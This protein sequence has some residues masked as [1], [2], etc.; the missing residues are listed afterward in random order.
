M[1][2]AFS[3][4]EL[5]R[6]DVQALLALH[7]QAMRAASPPHACHVLALDSLRDP[8]ITFWS[9]RADGRLVAIGALKHLSGDHGEVKS[10][11]TDPAGTGRGVG[12][13]MLAHILAAARQRG[14]R[15]VSLETGSTAEFLPAIRLYDRAGF[16]RC[17]AFGDY[18]ATDF[19][20]FMALDL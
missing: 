2:L 15:H 4:G 6:A 16:A 1:D 11:R 10:M 18:P 17:G 8:A 7:W 19:T 12:T 5:E 3:E 9:A 20:G 13:A 14:Y